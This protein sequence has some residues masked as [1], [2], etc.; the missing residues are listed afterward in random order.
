MHFLNEQRLRVYPRVAVTLAA[1]WWGMWILA[2][3]GLADPR[4]Q[5]IGGDFVTFYA[6]SELALHDRPED[7]YDPE[8]RYEAEQQVVESDRWERPWSYP[9]PLYLLVAPLASVPYLVAFAAWM[10]LMA[11]AYVLTARAIAP[12]PNMG[13]LAAASAGFLVCM[14]NG[15]T[16]ILM[17]VVLATGLLVLPRNPYAG[18]AILGLMILKPQLGLLV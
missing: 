11:T 13:W 9:P 15:Q 17:G 8:L 18:G 1:F 4:G 16:G 7:A 12:V 14:F 3:E 5:A 10:G 6:V 2:G